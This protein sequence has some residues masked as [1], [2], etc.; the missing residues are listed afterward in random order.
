MHFPRIVFLGAALPFL[1]PAQ[2][3]LSPDAAPTE[4]PKLEH[5]SAAIVDPS[6]NPCDDFYQY[7]CAKWMAANP[8]PADQP[9]WTTVGPLRLWN[10]TLLVETLEKFATNDPQRTATEQ[11]VGDYYFACMDE[12]SIEQHAREWLQQ[13]LGRIAALKSKRE[14]AREVAHLHQT[15]PGA[16]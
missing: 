3:T 11:K 7:V 10:E 2:K 1:A 9:S 8:I 6:V 16:W 15:I 14:L 4:L 5:F 12:T 13:E